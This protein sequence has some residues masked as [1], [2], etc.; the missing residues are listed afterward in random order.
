M[1]GKKVICPAY[2]SLTGSRTASHLA[3]PPAPSCSLLNIEELPQLVATIAGAESKH[4]DP[5]VGP[6]Q[7]DSMF[8]TTI[9]DSHSVFSGTLMLN[10]S[11]SVFVEPGHGVVWV[12]SL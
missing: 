8:E 1:V 11:V 5:S 3:W 6:T 12:I 9:A 4:A 10:V 2:E 7:A